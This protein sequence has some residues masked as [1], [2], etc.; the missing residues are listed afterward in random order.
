MKILNFF[1]IF[2]VL[3]IFE[4]F[5]ILNFKLFFVLIL[6]ICWKFLKFRNCFKF[7][8][9]WSFE[10]CCPMKKRFKGQFNSLS[11]NSL[12][13]TWRVNRSQGSKKRKNIFKYVVT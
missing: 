5:E 12:L 2:E 1:E 11:C 6:E 4:N 9:F 3:K 7:R 13:K 8:N 10:I